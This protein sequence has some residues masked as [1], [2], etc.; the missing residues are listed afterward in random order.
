A[1]VGRT[2]LAGYHWFTDWGRDT[3]ISLPGLCLCTRRFND[4]RAILA[5]FARFV[6]HGMLPNRFPD[7]GETPDYNTADAT[8]WY[9]EA[10][11][12]YERSSGDQQRP[13]GPRGI[14]DAAPLPGPVDG[15]VKPK[16]VSH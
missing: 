7:A 6:D 16:H 5:T 14:D 11:A 8:L 3:M 10:L 4:A 13:Q 9:F 1:S 2:I 12:Q 15:F